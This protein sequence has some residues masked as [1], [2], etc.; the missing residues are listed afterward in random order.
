MYYYYYYFITDR[1]IGWAMETFRRRLK[2]LYSSYCCCFGCSNACLY[3]L[4]VGCPHF[5]STVSWFCSRFGAIDALDGKEE[6]RKNG[7]KEGRKVFSSMHSCHAD[8]IEME[9]L[10]AGWLASCHILLFS[11]GKE[12]DR[13]TDGLPDRTFHN[14]TVSK[15]FDGRFQAT[16]NSLSY[17][18]WGLKFVK[19][20]VW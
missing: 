4:E 6:E 3:V 18:F 8:S 13:L 7:R 5:D 12:A 19:C 15:S 16:R 9:C 11:T 20:S 14:P 17:G 2:V 10:L 1:N